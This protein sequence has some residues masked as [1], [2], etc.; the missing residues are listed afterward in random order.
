VWTAKE[1]MQLKE[2][3]E[4]GVPGKEQARRLGRTYLSWHGA[5]K[6]HNLSH[7]TKHSNYDPYFREMIMNMICNG[8]M[9]KDIAK[10]RGNSTK[11]S[12]IRVIKEL[13][14]KGLLKKLKRGKYIPTRKWTHDN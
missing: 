6:R 13:V 8:F 2:W 11:S 14:G 7:K 10:A 9:I 1:V 4:I 3:Q 5:I 12:V